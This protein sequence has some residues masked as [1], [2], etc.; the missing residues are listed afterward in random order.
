MQ[1]HN[2][3]QVLFPVK[4]SVRNLYDMISN[5]VLTG[6][7]TAPVPVHT[8]LSQ[9]RPIIWNTV[10]YPRLPPFSLTEGSSESHGLIVQ[11]LHRLLYVP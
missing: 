8:L 9:K 11:I 2:G 1:F 5:G 10:K 3:Q 7:E 4:V 6:I